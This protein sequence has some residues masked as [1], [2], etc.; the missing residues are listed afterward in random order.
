MKSLLQRPLG[1]GGGEGNTCTQACTPTR[2]VL[3]DVTLVRHQNSHQIKWYPWTRGIHRPNQL[4]MMANVKGGSG[5]GLV[6][7]RLVSGWNHPHN[8]PTS[9]PPPH[10]HTS[11]HQ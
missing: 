1:W 8:P 9:P 10:H 6:G 4:L 2:D 11:H 7:E 5:G 3:G